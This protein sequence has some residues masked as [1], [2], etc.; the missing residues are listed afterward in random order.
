[1]VKVRAAP[2]TASISTRSRT[3]SQVQKAQIGIPPP[4]S[5]DDEGPSRRNRP[6]NP[7]MR[8]TRVPELHNPFHEPASCSFAN[9]DHPIDLLLS[10]ITC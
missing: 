5:S 8:R 9:R 10:A 4:F 2:S 1:M 3:W 6:L 7:Y